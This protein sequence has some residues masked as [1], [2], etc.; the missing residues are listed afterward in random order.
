MVSLTVCEVSS[1][2][3]GV[4]ETLPI[5]EREAAFAHSYR[6][7]GTAFR[8]CVMVRQYKKDLGT[9]RLSTTSVTA[10]VG[11]GTAV[12]GGAWLMFFVGLLY[13][14]KDPVRPSVTLEHRRYRLSDFHKI[15]HRS[16]LQ[17]GLYFSYGRH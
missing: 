15:R 12:G 1:F 3:R 17:M 8:P 7:F 13:K 5:V 11:F 14:V 4:A 16:S 2:H 9:D 10:N 6:R